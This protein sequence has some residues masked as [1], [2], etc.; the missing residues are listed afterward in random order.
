MTML[1]IVS[2]KKVFFETRVVAWQFTGGGVGLLSAISLHR[3]SQTC[4]V[5]LRSKDF[6]GQ[7]IRQY[8]IL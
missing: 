4:S 7:F 3:P 1:V 5:A 6:E 8:P 2:R